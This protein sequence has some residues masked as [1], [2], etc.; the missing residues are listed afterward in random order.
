MQSRLRPQSIPT[1][2]PRSSAQVQVNTEIRR[3]EIRREEN[4]RE[5]IRREEIRRERGD[6]RFSQRRGRGSRRR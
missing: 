2:D 5:E 1:S 4:R 3:E 6:R